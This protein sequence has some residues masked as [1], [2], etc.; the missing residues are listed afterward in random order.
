MNLQGTY[1][2]EN[3]T[4]ND[5]YTD[6]AS[7]GSH[8]AE[9]VD[10]RVKKLHEFLFRKGNKHP[11]GTVYYVLV[12]RV[13][14][15]WYVRAKEFDVELDWNHDPYIR[16]HKNMDVEGGPDIWEK[17]NKELT[18]I[19]DGPTPPIHYHCLMAERAKNFC[20][21]HREFVQ[22]HRDRIYPAYVLAYQRQINGECV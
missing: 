2:A 9:A 1:F 6:S 7:H 12:C 5:Q 3:L 21:R 16:G 19:P 17:F 22:Y 8:T 18:V 14:A 10:E 13:V 11:E 15:G 20:E 4:K